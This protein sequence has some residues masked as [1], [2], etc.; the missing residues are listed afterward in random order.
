[1][2]N[3]L[4]NSVDKTLREKGVYINPLIAPSVFKKVA[5]EMKK[6]YNNVQIDY[7]NQTIK[8]S[9]NNTEITTSND[10]IKRYEVK[11]RKSVANKLKEIYNTDSISA[12]LRIAIREA[13]EK[14]GINVDIDI[15]QREKKLEEILT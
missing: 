7:V 6:K 8:L 1:M 5:E 3:D 9:V 14:H 11:L 12:A 10:E 4:L 13:L 2:S 15:K